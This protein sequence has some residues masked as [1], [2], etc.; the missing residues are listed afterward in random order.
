M[1]SIDQIQG[2]VDANCKVHDI[3]NLFKQT[4]FKFIDEE[5]RTPKMIKATLLGSKNFFYNSNAFFF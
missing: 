1:N 4:D 5:I 3:N 2:V